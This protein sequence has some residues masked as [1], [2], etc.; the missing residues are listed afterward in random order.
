MDVL[1]FVMEFSMPRSVPQVPLPGT[2]QALAAVA[3]DAKVC[4]P[5]MM[6]PPTRPPDDAEIA[7]ARLAAIVDTSDDAI[8]S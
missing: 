5:R 2:K 3:P 6:P 4:D 8:I 1:R 7:A